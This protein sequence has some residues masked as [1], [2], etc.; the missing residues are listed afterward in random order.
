MTS[1]PAIEWNSDATIQPNALAARMKTIGTAQSFCEWSL[2]ERFLELG[3]EEYTPPYTRDS[4]GD[5]L[6]SLDIFLATIRSIR[7]FSRSKRAPTSCFMSFLLKREK[8]LEWM[9]RATDRP[10][11]LFLHKEGRYL[12]YNW[13]RCGCSGKCLAFRLHMNIPT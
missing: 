5:V 8:N 3:T 13:L 9:A 11:E 10:S 2:Y 7:P 4:C 12:R 6:N 1:A